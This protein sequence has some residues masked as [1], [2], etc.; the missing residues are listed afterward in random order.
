MKSHTG[1][2]KYVFPSV[3]TRSGSR[4]LSDIALLA[5]LRSMGYGSDEMTVHGFRHTASTLLNESGLWSGDAIERQLAHVE[6]NRIRGTYN[7]AEYL[8]ERRRMMQWWA[9]YL[10]E[11][12][13]KT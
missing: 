11:L 8:P 13:A 5:A 3:R 7:H 6:K 1:H 2:G 12:R 10:D 4:P 9:D